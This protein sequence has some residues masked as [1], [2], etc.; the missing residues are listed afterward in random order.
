MQ[1]ICGYSCPSVQYA[2]AWVVITTTV[3]VLFPD[4]DGSFGISCMS[5]SDAGIDD[6]AHV[7]H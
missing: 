3:F 4:G 2:I 6:I 7:A 1:A 5:I